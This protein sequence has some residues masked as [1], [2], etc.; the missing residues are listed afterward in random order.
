MERIP[1]LVSYLLDVVCDNTGD[2]P[3][4]NPKLLQDVL[5]QCLIHQV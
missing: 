4:T 1:E 3:V 5:L 2:V